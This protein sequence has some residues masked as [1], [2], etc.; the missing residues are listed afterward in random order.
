[1]REDTKYMNG[2]M[3]AYGYINEKMS[4]SEAE[5]LLKK[6]AEIKVDMTEG[7][8]EAGDKLVKMKFKD[9]ES[10]DDYLKKNWKM[11]DAG[12][13][14]MFMVITLES[15]SKLKKF[16]YDH[17]KKEKSFTDQLKNYFKNNVTP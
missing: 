14:K 1:M 4:D 2:I 6:I 10:F 11:P 17:G 13:D 16:R 12:Y 3:E 15:G 9:I 5:D 8:I 7:S